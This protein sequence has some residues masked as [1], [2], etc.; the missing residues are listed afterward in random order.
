M[1]AA[2][3]YLIT[4]LP[5]L[6]L[7]DKNL[8]YTEQG[9]RLQLQE[10]L[11]EQEIAIIRGL[12]YT[13]DIRNFINLIKH[14]TEAFDDRGNFTKEELLAAKTVPEILPVFMETFV[15]STQRSWETASYHD[16]LNDLT[17]RFI[18]WTRELPN[19]FL[20]EWFEFNHNLKNIIAGLNSRKFK[21]EIDREVLGSHFEAEQIIRSK[22]TDFGLSRVVDYVERV[23]AYFHDNDIAL[24]ESS[25]DLLRWAY[26]EALEEPYHFRLENVMAYI[27]KI[28]LIGR[29]I[30]ND[31]D[32]GKIKL[33]SI[34]NKIQTGFEL[35]EQFY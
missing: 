7:Q 21:R 13:Y 34:L 10:F 3:Y 12:Y 23:V 24:R 15:L 27:L 16:L 8:L 29:N 5:E 32:E 30:S 1:A 19:D 28:R 14:D 26:I 18:E 6:S 2:H 22:D 35:P 4:S 11:D 17:T 31:Y 33:N 9:F 25:F 20:R